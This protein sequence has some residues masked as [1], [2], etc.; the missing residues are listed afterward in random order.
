MQVPAQERY[1]AKKHQAEPKTYKISENGKT[2][3]VSKREN[4]KFFIELVPGG[5][6]HKLMAGEFTHEDIAHKAI[7]NYL[8]NK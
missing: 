3:R 7:R 8:A 4:G 2:I 5:E 1:A 6:V